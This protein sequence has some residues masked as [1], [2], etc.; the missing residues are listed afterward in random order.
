VGRYSVLIYSGQRSPPALHP[1][2]ASDALTA[3]DIADDLMSRSPSAVGVEVVRDGE[4]IYARGVVP[5]VVAPGRQV[6]LADGAAPRRTVRGHQAA[7][8][9]R[10]L[11]SART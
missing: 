10:S 9:S 2:A 7:A 8:A 4:R 1:V 6:A 5:V 3:S 11:A